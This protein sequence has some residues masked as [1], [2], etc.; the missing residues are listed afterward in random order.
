MEKRVQEE[1]KP[2]VFG[3]Q[4]RHRPTKWLH[5]GLGR[6]H[7]VRRPALARPVAQRCRGNSLGSD[8]CMAVVGSP[9]YFERYPKP[10]SPADLAAHACIRSRLPNGAPYR[11]EFAERDETLNIDVPGQLVLDAPALMLDAVR[12]GLG[13][14]H[15]A[16][17]YVLDDLATG[18]LLRV[19]DDWTPPYPGL[20][21]YYHS[22]CPSARACRAPRPLPPPGD[23]SKA[24][25]AMAIVS[26]LSPF[27]VVSVEIEGTR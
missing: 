19:L 24:V 23:R 21:L 10:Q 15:I 8:L 6:R 16:E 7:Q 2:T 12:S 20:A 5:R 25:M 17:W 26:V 18:R 22:A 14:A 11:W 3:F 4:F 27:A 1:R 13:L 9:T